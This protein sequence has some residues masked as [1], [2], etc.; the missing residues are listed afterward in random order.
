MVRK[1]KLTNPL[2]LAVLSV[3]IGG[4]MHPYEIARLL[5]HWGK[6]ESIKI[7]YGSL[8]T[9]VQDL[10]KRG[11]VEAEG[12]ARA[13]HRPERTVYRLTDD[14][15]RELEERLRE[16]IS[17]PA[18]EYPVFASALSLVTVLHPDDVTLLLG[19]RLRTLELEIVATRA[20]L[21]EL[22]GAQRLPRIFVLESE[23]ALAMKQAEATWVRSVISE[24]ADGS[25]PHVKQWRR[26]HETGQFPE[27]LL[28]T[29][30]A[31]ADQALFS[32]LIAAA[33][34][35][36]PHT[37]PQTGESDGEVNDPD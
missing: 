6:E 26:W 36:Q 1:R 16:L 37:R 3:L 12:T 19:E 2:A 15:R 13:G 8:Y 33:P 30:W 20:T 5:K 31:Q 27:E 24:L 14:G 10:E 7:R 4:P 18:K 35:A 29:D 11:F 23:Y 9:V 17:E 34:Q 22:V 28:D 21:D 25:L 32:Q